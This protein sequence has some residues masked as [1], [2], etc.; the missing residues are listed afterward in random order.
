MLR[1]RSQQVDELQHRMTRIMFH[2][3][4]MIK[5][6]SQFIASRIKSTNPK[7]ILK[8]GFAIV[9]QNDSIISSVKKTVPEKSATIEFHDG[10]VDV[11]II[12]KK[13]NVKERN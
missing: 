4:S 2:S 9:H 11:E 5:Q 3:F 10:L 7:S 6:R 8:R 13:N 1:Q 12:R